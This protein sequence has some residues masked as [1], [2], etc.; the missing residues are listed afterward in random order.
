[1]NTPA[2][3][4]KRIPTLSNLF[5]FDV[6]RLQMHVQIPNEITYNN[7]VGVWYCQA[8]RMDSARS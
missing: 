3:A 8:M 5:G 2:Q 7:G 4:P 6:P 1:M